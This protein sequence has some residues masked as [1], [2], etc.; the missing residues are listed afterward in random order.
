MVEG[1]TSE[2]WRVAGTRRAVADFDG[3]SLGAPMPA[4]GGAGGTDEAAAEAAAEGGGALA[5]S[6][7]P[8]SLAFPASPN[9]AAAATLTLVAAQHGG[10]AASNGDARQPCKQVRAGDAPPTQGEEAA[11]GAAAKGRPSNA[12]CADGADCLQLAK[13]PAAPQS[14]LVHH[15]AGRRPVSRRA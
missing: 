2:G 12:E 3:S 15:D 6:S 10:S 1:A 4:A 11:G 8:A 5:A 9:S 7:S 13:L 14:V